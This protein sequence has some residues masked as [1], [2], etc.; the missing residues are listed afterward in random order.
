M[1]VAADPA[2]FLFARG[3]EVL[4]GQLQVPVD[5][6]RLDEGT[7]LAAD[8]LEKPPV[9]GAE[10]VPGRVHLEPQPTHERPAHHELDHARGS[11]RLTDRG[12]DRIVA[13]A[14]HLDGG[15]GQLEPP[16]QECQ[17]SRAGRRWAR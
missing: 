16:G 3:D 12:L 5:R 13:L 11:A 17:A 15:P 7:H 4:A 2:P 9:G 14:V 10:R 1:E 6:H 8:V